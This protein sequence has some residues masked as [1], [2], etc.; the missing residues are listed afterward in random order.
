MLPQDSAHQLDFANTDPLRD[1]SDQAASNQT[2]T[3]LKAV[4]LS[5]GRSFPSCNFFEVHLFVINYFS[6]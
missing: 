1:N 4:G 2:T 5:H 3:F 6:N